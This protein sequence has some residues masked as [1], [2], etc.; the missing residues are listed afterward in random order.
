MRWKWVH[1][2]TPVFLRCKER[3]EYSGGAESLV[4]VVRIGKWSELTGK[5]AS[6]MGAVVCRNLNPL[7][8]LLK[9]RS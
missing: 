3:E 1:L 7:Q 2:V 4:K 9:N 8:S 6:L 5:R